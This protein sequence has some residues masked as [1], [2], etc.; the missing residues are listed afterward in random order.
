[1]G[2]VFRKSGL[3]GY[4]LPP[5]KKEKDKDGVV[6]SLSVPCKIA[7]L[8]LLF[9]IIIFFVSQ[10]HSFTTPKEIFPL[11]LLV[12]L[13]S[14]S[15]SKPKHNSSILNNILGT[16]RHKTSE[17]KENSVIQM[18][19]WMGSGLFPCSLTHCA[20]CMIV[21]EKCLRLGQWPSSHVCSHVHH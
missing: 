5:G 8:F 1:M 16:E 3:P 18:T 21:G 7:C 12:L 19:E 11:L 13:P 9:I 15:L 14:F 2:V 20:K 4:Y 6:E 10:W 17:L